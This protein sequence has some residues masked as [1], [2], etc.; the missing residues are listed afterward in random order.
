MQRRGEGKFFFPCLAS[1]RVFEGQKL[2]VLEI[3]LVKSDFSFSFRKALTVLVLHFPRM[4]HGTCSCFFSLGSSVKVRGV[5]CLLLFLRQ[6][7]PSSSD[8]SF[9]SRRLRK[10]RKK[11]R[12]S[13]PALV[14]LIP[15]RRTSSARPRFFSMI[16]F[17]K[18]IDPHTLYSRAD[19]PF[20]VFFFFPPYFREKWACL[21]GLLPFNSLQEKKRRMGWRALSFRGRRENGARN[22]QFRVSRV[23]RQ[24][25]LIKYKNLK[26][27]H[28]N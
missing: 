19:F 28:V 22:G 24:N 8:T 4:L 9:P 7:P 26:A 18:R 15:S 6:F 3:V 16:T 17:L 20:F 13:Q 21:F 14:A 11:Y 1:K 23:F 5:D 25:V 12:K 10:K 2:Q 27:N